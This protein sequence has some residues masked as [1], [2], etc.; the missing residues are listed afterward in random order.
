MWTRDKTYD[1]VIEGL[2]PYNDEFYQR[3]ELFSEEE[4]RINLFNLM[5]LTDKALNVAQKKKKLI[6]MKEFK[7]QAAKMLDQITGVKS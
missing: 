6:K 3:Y 7:R 4:E 2:P 1:T 5:K